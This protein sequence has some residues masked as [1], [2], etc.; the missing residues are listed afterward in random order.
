MQTR[1]HRLQ[2][3]GRS[4]RAHRGWS[5]C[6]PGTAGPGGIIR[7]HPVQPP[8]EDELCLKHCQCLK[9]SLFNLYFKTCVNDFIMFSGNVLQGFAKLPSGLFSPNASSKG[10]Q[11]L[12]ILWTGEEGFG[13][14]FYC[15]LCDSFL[16]MWILLQSLLLQTKQTKFFQFLHTKWCCL[17]LSSFLSLSTGLFPI[18]PQPPWSVMSETGY[19]V[20]AQISLD[21]IRT[22]W[23]KRLFHMNLMGNAYLFGLVWNLLSHNNMTLLTHD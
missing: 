10:R 9:S 12:L 6:S 23:S 2:T 3:P 4:P 21:L 13:V 22:N 20:P 11:L 1:S 5:V 17:A 19:S 15:L 7:S 8:P 16:Q 18:S 14:L